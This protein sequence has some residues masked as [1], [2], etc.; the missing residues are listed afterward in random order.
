VKI[1]AKRRHGTGFTLS[2][3]EPNLFRSRRVAPHHCQAPG[4]RK[5]RP[6]RNAA[7]A[8]K[9]CRRER[10]YG[11][12]GH[13]NRVEPPVRPFHDSRRQSSLYPGNGHDLLDV[14]GEIGQQVDR[15][16]AAKGNRPDRVLRL[17][18][19]VIGANRDDWSVA[20]SDDDR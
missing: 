11:A 2:I 13:V 5:R 18:A 1:V 20:G 4:F 9:H 14:S 17:I 15:L 7:V 16:A 10:G 19:V 12:A 8:G 6:I 3:A